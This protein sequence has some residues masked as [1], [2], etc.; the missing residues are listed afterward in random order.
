MFSRESTCKCSSNVFIPHAHCNLSPIESSFH[1]SWLIHKIILLSQAQ[2]LFSILP[3]SLNTQIESAPKTQKTEPHPFYAT[4]PQI[5]STSTDSRC[6][7]KFPHTQ[8][9]NV[10]LYSSAPTLSQSFAPLLSAAFSRCVFLFL[11]VVTLR[12]KRAQTEEK[13]FWNPIYPFPRLCL[14]S[15]CFMFTPLSLCL[16]Q[17]MTLTEESHSLCFNRDLDS[18]DMLGERCE[19]TS[20]PWEFI[21]F[22]TKE[23][24]WSISAEYIAD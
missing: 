23:R 15:Y 12:A 11:S 14:S 7:L 8:N 19:Y 13:S 4:F 6:T 3:S 17:I 9:H 5:L 24:N 21:L 2:T 22:L 10:I 16:R 20:P 1:S 18:A